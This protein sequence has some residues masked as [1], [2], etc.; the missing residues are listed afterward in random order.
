MESQPDPLQQLIREGEDDNLLKTTSSYPSFFFPPTKQNLKESTGEVM[1]QKQF[2]PWQ[3]ES[4]DFMEYN[5]L[6]CIQ[7]SPKLSRQ[8]RSGLQLLRG[9]SAGKERKLFP[10][11]QHESEKKRLLER[12]EGGRRR[13]GNRKG[14]R[15]RLF[16]ISSPGIT[17]FSHSSTKSQLLSRYFV[18]T[19][20]SIS[21]CLQH[22]VLKTFLFDFCI[23]NEYAIFNF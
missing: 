12:G 3:V 21:L 19:Y 4:Y 17:D 20:L 13:E 6:I 9:L 8:G 14:G 5:Q 15:E 22:L 1:L 7:F 18:S 23:K 16:Y 11:T 10:Q 2:K